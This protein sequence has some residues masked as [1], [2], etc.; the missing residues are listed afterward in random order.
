MPPPRPPPER[1]PEKGTVYDT[2]GPCPS[3]RSTLKPVFGQMPLYMQAGLVL[4][5]HAHNKYYELVMVLNN[6]SGI[7]F[8][9]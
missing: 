3:I 5:A 8:G 2:R 9:C 6:A 7:Y 4:S 1:N